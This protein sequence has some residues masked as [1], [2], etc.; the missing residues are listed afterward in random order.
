MRVP[1]NNVDPT[2]LAALEKSV[3]VRQRIRR[4]ARDSESVR[5]VEGLAIAIFLLYFAV[6]VWQRCFR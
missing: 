3:T 2:R 1:K 6:M 4:E 5:V